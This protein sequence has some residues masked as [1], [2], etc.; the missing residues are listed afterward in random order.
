VEPA[1]DYYYIPPPSPQLRPST[2]E[3]HQSSR[4]SVASFGSPPSA[5]SIH[6]QD[7]DTTRRP[8]LLKSLFGAGSRKDSR[9]SLADSAGSGS[10]VERAPSE[11]SGGAG[12]TGGYHQVCTGWEVGLP[13]FVNFEPRLPEVCQPAMASVTKHWARSSDVPGLG[14]MQSHVLSDLVSAC[15][16]IR[17]ECV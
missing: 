15:R 13:E 2:P 6:F 12:G 1:P 3:D 8:S 16:S 5:R 9:V 7:A 10:G 4:R 14:H 17:R 11:T